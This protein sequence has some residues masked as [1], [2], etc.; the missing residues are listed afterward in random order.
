VAAAQP[1]SEQSPPFARHVLQRTVV[2]PEHRVLFVPVPKAGC[3]SLLWMLAAL[4]GVSPDWFAD[5]AQPEVSPSL[6]V[7]DMSRWPAGH[8]LS[9]YAEAERARML[10]AEDW[11]RFS[12]V[13]HPATRLWSAWQS[14]LLLRE[15]RFAEAYG[16]EPWFPRLPGR[17]ADLVADFRRFAVAACGPAAGA[18]VHWAV[19]HE[20]LDGLPLAHVGRVE[21]LDRTLAV[22]RAHLGPGVEL[23]APAQANPGPLPMPPHAY[24]AATAATLRQRFR[25]DFDRY[26]YAAEL[27]GRGTATEWEA[28]AAAVIG[29]VRAAV[30]GHARLGQLHRVAERR[31]RRAQRA[32]ALL[33]TRSARRVGPAHA[34]ALTNREGETDFNVRWGWADGATAPGFTVVLRVRNEARPLPWVLPP[35]L[36]AA[37]RVVLI[38][39]GSTDG[40]AVLARRIALAEGAGDRLGV[41]AYPFAVARCGAEHLATPGDSVHSLAYFYNWSFAHVRTS[42]A[43]KWDGDMVLTD[44]AVQTLRDLA[45]QLEATQTVV[46]VPRH[47]L[48]VADERRAFIDLELRNCEPWAWPNRPGFSFVKAMEWE[49]PL[50][51]CPVDGIELPD[52]GCVELKH[53]SAD[54]FGH[55]SATGF[56][57]SA[58]TARKRREWEVFRALR[59]GGEPPAGVVAIVAPDGRHVIDYVRDT[60]LP[61]RAAA[62]TQPPARHGAPSHVISRWRRRDSLAS[63]RAA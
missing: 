19:Q 14:K 43:L 58:R 1:L 51:G 54:E 41:H 17:P 21:H 18:D 29:L 63:S 56:D 36:R 39:N 28:Q 62:R 42:Y 46:R 32:E 57:E 20:L 4:A 59:T 9:D 23:P 12:V 50:W 30:D 45:W 55:W 44:A 37:R 22:L 2:L 33:E 6:T 27:P 24:D 35:L 49:L 47:P 52:F 7:H 5:S 34:P 10:A 53:L 16:A 25:A 40:T 38:D 13:R 11:L 8:R 61:E 31:G 60:W 48:Y 26:G 3:S 15:P